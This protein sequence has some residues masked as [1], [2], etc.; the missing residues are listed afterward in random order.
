MM[1]GS[2]SPH[3]LISLCLSLPRGGR[4]AG[5]MHARI[6]IMA[7]IKPRYSKEEFAARADAIYE[8]DVRP[9]LTVDDARKFVAIDVESGEFEIAE[10]ELTAG[11]RLR[12]RVPQAQVWLVRAGSRY[13]HRFGGRD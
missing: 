8:R 3:L 9:R 1:G 6:K 2:L 11:D 7:K 12:D 10:D 13:L 4:V 5:D